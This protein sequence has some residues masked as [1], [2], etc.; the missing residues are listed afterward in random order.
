MKILTA[1]LTDGLPAVE[2]AC[3]ESLAA[4]I[5]A[6]DVILNVLVRHSDADV[7]ARINPPERLNLVL[8][9]LADCARYDALR[10]SMEVCHVA[11]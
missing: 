7:V 3:E 8:P 9:P 1:V 11:Q 10:G 5:A 2:A 6:A 4:G